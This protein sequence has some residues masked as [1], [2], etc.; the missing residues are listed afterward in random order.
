[1]LTLFGNLDSG[2][3]HKVQMI[4]KYR[5]LPFRRVDVRQDRGQPRDPRF[6]DV[7]KIGKVPAVRFSDGTVLSESGALLFYFSSQTPL[8]PGGIRAQAE[9]LRW[10]F[11]EQYS[12]EPALAVLRYLQRFVP[13]P[14]LHRER[15][16]DL[17]A[18]S[19][20]VLGVLEQ[21]LAESDWIAGPTTTIAD[22]ALYPY[23]RWMEEVGF[24]RRDWPAIDRW[25]VRF[26]RTPEF[27]PLYA[28]GASE[29][30]EFSDYFRLAS[31]GD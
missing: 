27:L 17:E 18:K 24:A 29:V 25:L 21:R 16:A 20:F 28:D 23:T 10:M 6:R 4:L 12:H 26:E 7:N 3:V 5:G 19:K 2:N 15:I 30:L 1:M 8:W 22:F 13:D 11:F 14:D 31:H 9:V